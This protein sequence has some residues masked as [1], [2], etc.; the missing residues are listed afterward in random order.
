MGEAKRRRGPGTDHTIASRITRRPNA[1]G[2]PFVYRPHCVALYLGLRKLGAEKEAGFF[3]NVDSPSLEAFWQ[4][5]PS[6]CMK[7]TAG[8]GVYGDVGVRTASMLQASLSAGHHK[9]S[10]EQRA[11]LAQAALW[12]FM[13]NHAK[14]GERDLML[15]G[16]VFIQL[17]LEETSPALFDTHS[18]F[19]DLRA[20]EV[21]A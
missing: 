2:I 11:M 3:V 19:L 5:W 20:P 16:D 8:T 9:N 1:S 13:A 4:E 12:F 10:A 14:P 15:R 18:S 17:R 6:V 21:V 7:S